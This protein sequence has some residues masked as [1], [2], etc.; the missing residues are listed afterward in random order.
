[1]SIV[2]VLTAKRKYSLTGLKKARLGEAHGEKPIKR[3][4]FCIRIRGE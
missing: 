2:N 1:M 4:V 3:P